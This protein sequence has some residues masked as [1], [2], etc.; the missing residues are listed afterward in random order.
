MNT[1]GFV[2]KNCQETSSL[3]YTVSEHQVIHR[4]LPDRRKKLQHGL[5]THDAD[6]LFRQVN[7][8]SYKPKELS[9]ID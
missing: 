3:S 1:S 2:T 4:L 5:E 8:S 7:N 9:K 6:L